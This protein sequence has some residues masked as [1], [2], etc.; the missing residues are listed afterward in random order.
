MIYANTNS[1]SATER[2]RMN[3]RCQPVHPNTTD[4]YI[5]PQ[6]NI[7]STQNYN[8]DIFSQIKNMLDIKQALEYYGLSFKNNN[9]TSCPFHQ[10]KT[11]SFKIYDDSFYCFGCGASGTVID[12]VMKYFGLTNIEAVKKLKL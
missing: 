8:I 11:P 3:I 4:I 9:F 7:K 6:K 10:E 2:E 12:F 1:L 5:I